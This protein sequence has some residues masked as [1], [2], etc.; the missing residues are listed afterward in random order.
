MSIKLS[1]LS[2]EN[3]QAGY[4]KKDLPE[5]YA[6]A[7]VIENGPWHNN[8]NVFEHTMAVFKQ[9]ELLFKEN[10]LKSQI[11]E[12]LKLKVGKHTRKELLTISVLL[13]DIAKPVTFVK[14]KTGMVRCPGHEFFGS[15]MIK[16]F[17]SRFGFDKK[18]EAFVRNIVFYHGYIVE[19]LNQIMD[20]GN[21]KYY[22]E[23]YKEIVGNIY[24]ELVLLFYSDLLGSDLKQSN[25]EEFNKRKNLTLEFLQY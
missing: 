24:C 22:I 19:T 16:L 13:H 18:D 17:S 10:I 8:Q 14:D 15:N 11:I 25:P 21:K 12:Q 3:F 5:I 6:L 4:F 20:K 9:F 23:S 1:L 2:S 7:K